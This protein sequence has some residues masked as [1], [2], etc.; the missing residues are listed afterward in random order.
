M[1]EL[2]KSVLKLSPIPFSKNHLY[3]IQTRYI[4]KHYLR[5]DSNCIDAGCHKGEI[6]DLIL[7]F[8][9]EGSHWGFE[10]NPDL[11]R[12]LVRKYQR[13]NNIHILNYALSNTKGISVFNL[14]L[15]NP[16]YSGLLKRDYDRRREVEQEIHVNTDLLDNIITCWN[17]DRFSEN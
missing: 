1:K 9:P 5:K 8:A 16:S 17:K 13:R 15:S 4:I 10:P 12:A 14:V 11:F 2:I 6:L 7:R 3:D